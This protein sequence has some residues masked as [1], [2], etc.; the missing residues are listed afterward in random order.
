MK[1]DIKNDAEMQNTKMITNHKFF[2]E[3]MI[4]KNVRN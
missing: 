1:Y 3:F 4:Y 2:Q